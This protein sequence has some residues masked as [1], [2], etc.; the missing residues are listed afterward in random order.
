MKYEI[1]SKQPYFAMPTPEERKNNLKRVLELCADKSNTEAPTRVAT[2]YEVSP[3]TVRRRLAGGRSREEAAVASRLITPEQEQILES[4]IIFLS[5]MNCP[6]TG[7]AVRSLAGQMSGQADHVASQNWLK[8]FI[9]RCHF[10]EH[11]RLGK[12]DLPRVRKNPTKLIDLFF[13]LYDYYRTKFNVHR[14][15]IWNLDECGVKIGE[16]M[17]K[18]TV[19]AHRNTRNVVT[20]DSGELVTVLELISARGTVGSPLFIYKGKH[21]MESW[22]PK[23]IGTPVHVGATYSSFITSE[24]FNEWFRDG[25]SCLDTEPG[26]WK[27]LLLDGHT[28]HTTT[29]FFDHAISRKVI[30]LFFPSH[31]T[32]ILQP[33]DASTFGTLKKLIRKEF[34]GKFV[35][36]LTPSK[37]NFFETYLGIRDQ[38]FTPR[39]IKEAF[40]LTGMIP[41]DRRIAKEKAQALEVPTEDI[42]T[43]APTSGPENS[44]STQVSGDK[45]QGITITNTVRSSPL[46]SNWRSARATFMNTK[47]P[48]ESLKLFKEVW[49]KMQE[50]RAE[51]TSWRNKSGRFENQYNEELA[52]RNTKRP[53]R[54]NDN[55]GVLLA[56]GIETGPDVPVTVEEFDEDPDV[57][58]S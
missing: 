4:H 30:P 31:M 33:L 51:A 48:A 6:P 12:V 45:S 13:D 15:D 26:K 58:T 50:F 43:P 9:K 55:G 46:D 52:K 3:T 14:D 47:C 38:V 49:D 23:K 1:P 18:C 42:S 34:Y 41:P 54:K 36:G 27:I 17:N 10:L 39:G 35:D 32:H 40:R 57:P 8:G 19:V 2:N 29:K 28:T 25:T 53:R 21:F 11:T 24:I 16:T 5:Q 22:F 37:K 20:I 56:L 7:F 44:K